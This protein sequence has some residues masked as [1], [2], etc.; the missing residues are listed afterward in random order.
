M[1]VPEVSVDHATV[2]N[3]LDVEDDHNLN[4]QEDTSESDDD[5]DANAGNQSRHPHVPPRRYTGLLPRPNCTHIVMDYF[6]T[7]HIPCD[8]CG[9]PPRLGWLYVCQQDHYSEAMARRQIESLKTVNVKEQVPSRIEELQ[10]CGMSR[11]VVDQVKQGN[12]YDP[13]QIEVSG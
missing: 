9:L 1:A 5:D 12:V 6:Y 8:N 11:S 7:K 3:T 4:Q 13:I 2:D 10:A